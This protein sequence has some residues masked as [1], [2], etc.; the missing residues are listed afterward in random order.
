MTD[1]ENAAAEAELKDELL[2]EVAGGANKRYTREPKYSK[3]EYQRVGITLKSTG[4]GYCFVY[5]RQSISE[6]DA[7]RIVEEYRMFRE[8]DK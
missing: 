4:F 1:N 8:W 5:H 6:S 2:D 3:E 7:N